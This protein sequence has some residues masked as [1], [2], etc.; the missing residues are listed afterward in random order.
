METTTTR[1]GTAKAR[2]GGVKFVLLHHGGCLGGGFH[3]RIDADGG[4]RAELEESERGQ[5]ARSIAV[6][7]DGDFDDVAPSEAQLDA[8]RDLLLKLKL[9]YPTAEIGAHR[10][11][12]SGAQTTCPGKRFPMRALAEWSRN[13]LLSERDAVLRRDFESQYTQI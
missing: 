2:R 11:V 9:R 3:Y 12:R 5:H 4:V 10:Q 13:E 1:S 6:V 7:V 8:L